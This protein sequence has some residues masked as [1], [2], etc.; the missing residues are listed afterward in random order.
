MV[1][2]GHV[3]GYHG[4]TE[5]IAN[6]I[7]K[8]GFKA[9]VRKGLW[10]GTG[11][12]FF[13]D[14]PHHAYRWARDRIA[15]K[16]GGTPTVV[17]ATLRLDECLDLLDA[18]FWGYIDGIWRSYFRQFSGEQLD[19]TALVDDNYAKTGLVGRNIVDAQ[20]MNLA[21]Q[22]LR[23]VLAHSGKGL[24]T[25]RAAFIEGRPIHPTS[26]IFD[27]SHVVVVALDSSPVSDIQT[28]RIS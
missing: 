14:G 2:G 10:L 28:V 19:I 7:L 15:P 22:K 5:E 18:T 17:R 20:V 26:W 9:S 3:Y 6:K 25:L 8:E 27:E 4:T 1:F 16:L 21:V 13:Q 11:A 23:E 12:Y 24:T